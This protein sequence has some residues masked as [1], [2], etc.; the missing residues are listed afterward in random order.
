MKTFKVLSFLIA[1]IFCGGLVSAQ[2]ANAIIAKY[3]KAIGGKKKISRITSLY[4]ESTADIMGNESLQKVTV[5]NGKG[6]KQEMD[7][8]GSVMTTCYTESGGWTINPM[9]G[10]GSP[11]SM[12][13]DQYKEGKDQIY[14]GGPFIKYKD[15]GYKTEI[16]GNDTIGNVNALKVELTTPDNTSNVYFFDPETGYLIQ[17]IQQAEMQGQMV[18]NIISYSDYKEVDGIV[19]PHTIAINIG[20]MFEMTNKVTKVEVNKPVDPAFFEKPE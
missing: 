12:T 7:I 4:T 19:L 13:E 9:M 15:P 1:F 3:L 8:M 16:M 17:S 14:I 5:L 6:Y 18:E 11:E 20:G 2:D 10:N